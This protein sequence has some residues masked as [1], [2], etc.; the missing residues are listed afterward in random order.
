MK[1]VWMSLVIVLFTGMATAQKTE[2]TF[3]IRF[4]D[5]SI[6]TLKAIHERTAKKSVHDVRTQSETRILMISVQMESEIVVTKEN[7]V[8]IEGTAYRQA[9]RG[10]SD[11]HSYTKKIGDK[12]YQRERNGESKKLEN[13]KIT[14]CVVD[15]YFTEPKGKTTIFS[16]M[17]GDFLKLK[18]L[19]PARYELITPD[20]KNSI[21]TYQ[22]GKLMLIEVNTPLG[23]VV[24][25]RK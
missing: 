12:T 10:A 5:E 15:L 19:G 23:K 6:G 9:N 7:G 20:D 16:N 21:Y 8:L 22:N 24:T 1:A 13:T 2:I 25:K 18:Q 17:Y 14:L 11:V 3:D 4:K